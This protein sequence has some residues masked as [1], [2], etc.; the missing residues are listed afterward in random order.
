MGTIFIFA[1][2]TDSFSSSEINSASDARQSFRLKLG[3]IHSAGTPLNQRRGPRG[4]SSVCGGARPRFADHCY[5]NKR[6]GGARVVMYRRALALVAVVAAAAAGDAPAGPYDNPICG[7]AEGLRA[8]P[9]PTSSRLCLLTN[10]TP[11]PRARAAALAARPPPPTPTASMPRSRARRMART[12]AFKPP[13][14]P[15]EGCGERRDGRARAPT[16]LRL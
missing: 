10:K 14:A 2:F 8:R 13:Q 1:F 4:R 11:R 6:A 15:V 5:L 3:V 9:T 16:I 12:L 7:T